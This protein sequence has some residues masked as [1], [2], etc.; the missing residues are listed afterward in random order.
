MNSKVKIIIAIVFFALAG[1]V[2]AYQFGVFGS[3]KPKKESGVVE[4]GTK[5]Q[6]PAVLNNEGGGPK[7]T[8]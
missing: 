1:L 5:G 8:G 3:G 6:A 4:T 7:P 2:V